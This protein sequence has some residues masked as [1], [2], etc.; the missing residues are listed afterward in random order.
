MKNKTSKTRKTKALNKHN[1]MPSA[2]IH[3]IL[4]H[5]KT[6]EVIEMP[7]L[8]IC[9]EYSHIAFSTKP[10]D[11]NGD[12]NGIG[13]LPTYPGNNTAKDYEVLVVINGITHIYNGLFWSPNKELLKDPVYDGDG[14]FF[15]RHWA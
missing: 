11:Y 13:R 2:S 3:F 4:K 9:E 12:F 14:S 1:V 6:G 10:S 5:K 7:I 15:G 8:N